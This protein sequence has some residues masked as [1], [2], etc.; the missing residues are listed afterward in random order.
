MKKTLTIISTYPQFGSKNIGDQLITNKLI[1]LIQKLG[2]YNIQIIWRAAPWNEVKD[3]I[4]S[5]DHI[6]FACLAIRPNMHSRE[7]PYLE[8][9]INSG[10]PFSV[11]SAGTD[12]PV[13]SRTKAEGSTVF[14]NFTPETKNIL[15]EINNKAITATTRGYLTQELCNRLDLKRFLFSGDIAFYNQNHSKEKF[16]KGKT[17]E[18]IIISDPHYPKIFMDSFKSLHKGIK[19]IFPESE[20]IVAQ[21]GINKDIDDFCKKNGIATKKIYE[22]PDSGLNIYDD[23]DL[24][25][26]FRVHAHVSALS[27]KKYSYLLE[28]DGRGCDYGITLSRKISVPSQP[29]PRINLSIKSIIKFILK[30]SRGPEGYVSTSATDQLLALIRMDANQGFEKF[31]GMEN[32]ISYFVKSTEESIKKSLDSIQSK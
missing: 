22:T 17:I 19:A 1:E 21:H 29:T 12:L 18:K 2:D 32:E 4:L 30:K 7:Y 3:I 5:S 25:V 14:D 16:T 26:G 15:Q 8:K 10:V 9:V 20:I 13:H 27:R 11:I 28:Q 24:H 6:F 31:V 23:A